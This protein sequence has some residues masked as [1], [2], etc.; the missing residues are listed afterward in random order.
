MGAIGYLPICSGSSNNITYIIPGIGCNVG[1]IKG[2]HHHFE[3]GR[4]TIS[5]SWNVGEGAWPPPMKSLAIDAILR[6]L[7]VEF[8]YQKCLDWTLWYILFK[9][10]LK[11]RRHQHWL[12][13]KKW[14][15]NHKVLENL[16][17]FYFQIFFQILFFFMVIFCR[18][19]Y[20]PA[21]KLP[22]PQSPALYCPQCPKF[23]YRI[24]TA[25]L[26]IQKNFNISLTPSPSDIW[27][28]QR[29]HYN[30]QHMMAHSSDIHYNQGWVVPFWG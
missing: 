22:D 14:N 27:N 5:K 25:D 2:P 12:H 20:F 30:V 23:C 8:K 9:L 19:G 6:T 26:V 29:N 15:P 13:G 4:A 1:R 18:F 21:F 11:E 7:H 28:Y 10:S 3:I 17:S 16:K 24:S